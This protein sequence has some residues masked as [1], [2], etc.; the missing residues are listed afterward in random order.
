MLKNEAIQLAAVTTSLEA[1][2]FVI[3][4]KVR[5]TGERT[6][7]AYGSPRRIYYDRASAKLRL[8]LHDHSMSE[9]EEKLISPHLKRPYFVPLEAQVATDIKIRLDPIIKRIRPALERGNGPMIEE[10]P[11]TEAQE[12]EIEIACQDTPFYYN[13]GLPNA[14]QL[15]QWADVISK[16]SFKLTPP[17]KD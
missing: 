6:L 5:N 2:K 12:I 7:H 13:P 4:I 17:M 15:K 8:V 3:T 11:I 1:D 14:Q 16:A 10:L 9:E